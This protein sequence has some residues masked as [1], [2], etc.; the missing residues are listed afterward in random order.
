[1]RAV[2]GF[3]ERFAVAEDLQLSYRLA[4]RG[5]R[6]AS[7]DAVLLDY[8]VHAGSITARGAVRR[9][10]CTL[11]AQLRGVRELRGRLSARGYAVL[12]QSG[13]RCALAAV[14]LRR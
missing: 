1:V 12:M 7:V 14:G 8:R 9:E 6:F 5:G 2:G 3:D 4:G 11:R 10:W 13:L